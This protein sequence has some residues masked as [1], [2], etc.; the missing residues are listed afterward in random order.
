[1][2]QLLYQTNDVQIATYRHYAE[3][4]L[5]GE[6]PIY[7]ELFHLQSDPEELHNVIQE[8]QHASVLS[9]LRTA[10]KEKLKYARGAGKP[11]VLRYTNTSK[12]ES[13]LKEKSKP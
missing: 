12:L 11:K 13:A 1:V 10:W 2:N 5:V 8:K 4:S 3:S 9:S 7:E 6:P